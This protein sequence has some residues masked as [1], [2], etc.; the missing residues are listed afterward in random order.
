MEIKSISLRSDIMVWVITAKKE[1]TIEDCGLWVQA[2]APK[3][4]EKEIRL[5]LKELRETAERDKTGITYEL[6]EL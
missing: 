2:T 3:S 4:A 6:D 5:L 1:S